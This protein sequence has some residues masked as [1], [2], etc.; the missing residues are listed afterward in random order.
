M[1]YS[2]DIY[3]WFSDCE[4]QDTDSY[5]PNS[6]M[7]WAPNDGIWWHVER[8][9]MQTVKVAVD[10]EQRILVFWAM[11]DPVV[12][13]I[14]ILMGVFQWWWVLR[15]VWE[16]RL[17]NRLFFFR[18]CKLSS[19]WWFGTF[20]IFP[21]IGNFIIPNWRTHIVQGR[22]GWTNHQPALTLACASVLILGL[23]IS[24]AK[25]QGISIHSNTRIC[26][27]R[28]YIM[29]ILLFLIDSFTCIYTYIHIYIYTYTYT[30][31]YSYTHTYIYIYIYIY[32]HIYIY[33]YTY[34]YIHIKPPLPVFTFQRYLVYLAESARGA[35]RSQLGAE[36]P[37]QR[38][39]QEVLLLGFS[40]RGVAQLLDGFFQRKSHENGWFRGIF[41][42]KSQSKDG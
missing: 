12:I 1:I 3:I 21:Y 32:I 33:I 17:Y 29:Y 19:G 4:T 22:G 38:R 37:T 24:P 36:L 41:H 6:I 5:Q 39:F 16:P 10:L 20:S 13:K 27:H 8:G 2:G 31:T 7:R 26:T 15:Q 9:K 14:L 40:S 25:S 35:Q 42:G 11:G 28:H 34:I 18:L 30:Y 23:S